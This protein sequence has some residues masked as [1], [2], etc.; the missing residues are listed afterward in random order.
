MK[1]ISLLGKIFK[2]GSLGKKS[3]C[4]QISK[5]GLSIALTKVK[6][7]LQILECKYFNGDLEVQQN[8][9]S[10][11]VAHNQLQHANCHIVLSRED[12]RLILIEK[13][14]VDDNEIEESVHWLI[15]DLI[16]FPIEQAVVDF[17]PAPVQTGQS[18]KIYVVVVNLQWLNTVAGMVKEAGLNLEAVNIAALAIR[19]VIS[20]LPIMGNSAIFLTQE[21]EYYYI[22]VVKDQLIYLERKLEFSSQGETNVRIFDDFCNR[23]IAELQRSIDFYQNRDKTILIKFFMDKLLGQNQKLIQ[24]IETAFNLRVEILDTNKWLSDNDKGMPLSNKI[25]CLSVIGESLEL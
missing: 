18:A 17:F 22:L 16:D 4:V 13:P 21:G 1:I 3:V 24:L 7:V 6:P 14:K 2:L 10:S 5:E 15:K 23:L 25:N 11:F 8:S 19:N 20:S 9:L 12:Y